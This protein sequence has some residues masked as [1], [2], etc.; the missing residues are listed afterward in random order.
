MKISF[1]PEL[2]CSQGHTVKTTWSELITISK[3]ETE[4]IS[5]NLSGMTLSE[6]SF[7]AK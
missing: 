5:G 6:I 7:A 3:T 4:L 2:D 1:R